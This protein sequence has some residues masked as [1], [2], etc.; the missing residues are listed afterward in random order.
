[1][2][3]VPWREE[4][5]LELAAESRERVLRDLGGRKPAQVPRQDGRPR[6]GAPFSSRVRREFYG[7]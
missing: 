4:A 2:A 7:A 3:E 6:L 1:V 5:L